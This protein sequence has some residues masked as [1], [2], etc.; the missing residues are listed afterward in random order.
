MGYQ[1]NLGVLVFLSA[2]GAGCL[3]TQKTT[4][5]V[6]K[7]TSKKALDAEK[8]SAESETFEAKIKLAG[9]SEF[10]GE[11]A[12]AKAQLG[13]SGYLVKAIPIKSEACAVTAPIE[14][15]IKYG[16]GGVLLVLVDGCQYQV[17]LDMGII[18]TNESGEQES[19]SLVMKDIFY[20]NSSTIL[21]DQATLPANHFISAEL[22]LLPAGT[23]AGFKTGKIKLEKL[24]T[25]VASNDEKIL[26]SPKS[27]GTPAPKGT[28]TDTGAFD[29]AAPTA[30]ASTPTT[31]ST[32]KPAPAAKDDPLNSF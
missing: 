4:Q 3:Q 7:N 11:S 31:T 27:T 30:P 1:K 6:P 9:D 32:P 28:T 25:D 15:T 2:F 12:A 26:S 8:E 19:E 10:T 23:Q 17:S 21:V 14:E 5:P 22:A 20:T 16:S 24:G 13:N 18:G 29:N